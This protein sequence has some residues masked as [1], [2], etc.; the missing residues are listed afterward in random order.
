MYEIVK[1]K[2]F[3]LYVTSKTNKLNASQVRSKTGADI[4]I[5]CTL[6]NPT[7]WVPVCDVKCD[8]KVLSDD[9]YGYWGFGWNKNDN[10]MVMTNNIN[11]YENYITSVALI[12]DGKDTI[13]TANADVRRAAGRTAI[14]FRADGQMV[15]WCTKEGAPNMTLETLRSKLYELGCEYALALDGGGSSQLSQEGENYIYSSRKVQNY[16]CIWVEKPEQEKSDNPY[17]YPTRTLK[18]GMSGDD[19]RWVQY[20]LNRKMG[21]NIDLYSGDFWTITEQAVKD[22]QKKNGLIVDGIVGP[23][24]RDK[25]NG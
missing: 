16:L 18:L 23:K 11:T 22:F 19:V 5:N 21:M 20:E 8:G 10:T 9:Q 4:V 17:T 24:T 13:I 6:Y 1:P 15:I 2:K 3:Q 25:L 12:K 7:K 14:G